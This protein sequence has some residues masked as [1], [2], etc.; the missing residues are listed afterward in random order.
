MSLSHFMGG[1][2]EPREAGLFIQGHLADVPPS[3]V[4]NLTLTLVLA[5]PGLRASAGWSWAGARP[6]GRHP[7]PGPGRCRGLD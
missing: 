5:P 3:P 2:T 6:L 4:W 1:I 7:G